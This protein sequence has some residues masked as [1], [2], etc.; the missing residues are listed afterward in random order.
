MFLL[1]Q[2][3]HWPLALTLEAAMVWAG[4]SMC[5]RQSF[6]CALMAMPGGADSVRASPLEEVTC[7]ISVFL[8]LHPSVKVL[9]H[10]LEILCLLS[11]FP[12]KVRALQG[13][14]VGYVFFSFF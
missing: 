4:R 12:I 3:L 9:S 5:H 2:V 6:V 11:V 13:Q 7:L 1:W 14:G 10:Y 8:A